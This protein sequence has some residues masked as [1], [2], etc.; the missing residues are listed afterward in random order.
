M[1]NVFLIARYELVRLLSTRRGWVSIVAF[2]LVWLMLLYY[3]IFQ[4]SRVLAQDGGTGLVS[5]VLDMLGMDRLTSWAVPELAV[6]WFFGLMLLPFFCITLT[7]DQTA[8]DRSRGTLRFLVL[9]STRWQIF[10]GRYFGQMLVLLLFIVASL[11]TTL[12]VVFYRDA[13]ALPDWLA[14]VLPVLV[15]LMI[16]L[17]PYTALMALVS[18]LAKSA[19]QAT[20]YAIILWI[21][22]WFASRM[23]MNQLPGLEFLNWAMPGSQIRAL[24][25]SVGWDALRLA[26]IPLIQTLVL[27]LLGWWLMQRRDL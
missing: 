9:R 20:L 18:V 13:G 5:S 23:I 24:L 7:A 17:L 1:K 11:V 22:V 4:A 14:L 16:V 27:L 8:S 12:P 2:A 25:T 26:H 19:R 6:Y 21:V 10:F 15:N 3:V